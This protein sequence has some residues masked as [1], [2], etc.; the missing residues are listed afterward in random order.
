MSNSVLG[1]IDAVS[2]G[3]TL[4]HEHI[5]WD[6]SGAESTNRYNAEEVVNTMLPCLLDLKYLGCNTFVDATI[7]GSALV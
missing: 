2:L 3:V 1:A 5:T 7:F 4:M 6:R